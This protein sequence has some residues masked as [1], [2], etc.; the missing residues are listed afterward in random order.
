MMS[1]DEA[2]EVGEG[3]QVPLQ[4]AHDREGLALPGPRRTNASWATSWRQAR[5]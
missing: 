5:A 2:E 4:P 3:L 1:K